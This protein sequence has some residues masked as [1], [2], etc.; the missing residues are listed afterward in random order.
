MVLG[1][2]HQVTCILFLFVFLKIK[3]FNYTYIDLAGI[4]MILNNK[5]RPVF[6]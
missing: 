1:N 5:C 4:C 6:K 2:E 3:I